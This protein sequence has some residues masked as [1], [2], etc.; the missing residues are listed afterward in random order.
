MDNNRCEELL[1]KGIDCRKEG[2]FIQA[3]NF[4]EQAKEFNRDNFNIYLNMAKLEFGLG[5]MEVS[6]RNF[7]CYFHYFILYDKIKSNNLNYVMAEELLTNI[8]ECITKIGT[9]IKKDLHYLNVLSNGAINNVLIALGGEALLY[10]GATI[11]TFNQNISN[12]VGITRQMISNLQ[13]N[14]LNSNTSSDELKNFYSDI[15]QFIG[16]IAIT[17]NMSFSI[18]NSNQITNYYLSNKYVLKKLS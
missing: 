14:F 17:K 15:L 6:F 16:L 9:V 18:D 5:N 2:M 3:R 7:L 13:R 1:F 12:Q 10:S 8:M 11:L 4:Y